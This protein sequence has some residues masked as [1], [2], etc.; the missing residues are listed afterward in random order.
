MYD[1]FER[2]LGEKGIT[3]HK[4]QNGIPVNIDL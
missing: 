1:T 3:F 4:L 2:I